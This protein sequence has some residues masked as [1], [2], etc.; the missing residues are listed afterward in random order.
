MCR[1]W[2]MHFAVLPLGILSKFKLSV[3]KVQGKNPHGKSAHTPMSIAI[4]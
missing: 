1:S 4:K 3:L 2:N